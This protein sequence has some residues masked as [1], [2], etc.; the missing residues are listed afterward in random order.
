[1]KNN[2]FCEWL[3]KVII[4]LGN[5]DKINLQVRFQNLQC[6][7]SLLFSNFI[8]YHIN[9][10]CNSINVYFRSYY[11]INWQRKILRNLFLII[12]VYVSTYNLILIHF[13]PGVMN[14]WFPFNEDL[15]SKLFWCSWKMKTY[16]TLKIRNLASRL[17]WPS[18]Q[19]KL[20][21]TVIVLYITWMKFSIFLEGVKISL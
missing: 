14:Q 16:K 11:L 9:R 1:M 21:L 2:I 20:Y 6:F 5:L 13:W 19:E 17:F 8:N 15:I 12:F 10:M 18:S 4:S 7:V 3:I